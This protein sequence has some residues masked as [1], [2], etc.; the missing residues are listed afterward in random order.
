MHSL[1][2]RQHCVLFSQSAIWCIKVT[3]IWFICPDSISLLVVPVACSALLPTTPP[4]V[5]GIALY[6]SL[7]VDHCVC[8]VRR[9]F[10]CRTFCCSSVLQI[11][12]LFLSFFLVVLLIVLCSRCSRFAI[13]LY[14]VGTR[15]TSLLSAICSD[16]HHDW[17]L[18]SCCSY[19]YPSH[20]SGHSFFYRRV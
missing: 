3:Q 4:R 13:L 2:P 6:V 20:A 10:V 19:V 9:R 5:L 12:S 7:S 8:A 18:I 14:R 17:S 15:W 11:S 16:P 1:A